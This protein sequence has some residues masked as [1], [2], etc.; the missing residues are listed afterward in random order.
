MSGKPT[1]A[2]LLVGS[3]QATEEMLFKAG[4]DI[5][6]S[7]KSKFDAAFFLG[8][9]DVHPF[10]YGQKPLKQTVTDFNRD[11]I[12]NG[13]YRSLPK[14]MP[15]IGVCRGAQFLN[16]MSGGILWQHVTNHLQPHTI[17]CN[18]GEILDVP[19]DHHQMMIPT[20]DATEIAW[21]SCAYFK[22]NRIQTVKYDTNQRKEQWDDVEACYYADTHS[23]CVQFHPEYKASEGKAREKFFEWMDEYLW[24][25]EVA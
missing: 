15:K 24:A 5:T 16:V 20:R 25:K 2:I 8:G 3:D 4:Y 11:M 13:I 6:R 10:L 9:A 19:S 12:E 21:A 22:A 14:D 23:L 17:R 7:G 18:D 1:K